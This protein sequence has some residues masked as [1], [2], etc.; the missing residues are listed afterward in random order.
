LGNIGLKLTDTNE[1]IAEVGFM[2]KHDTQGK[3]NANEALNLIK[4][5]F[6]PL[7]LNK[8]VAVCSTGNSGAY[9]LLAK[10]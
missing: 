2:L 1:K 8:I 6:N 7:T 10:R 5:F 9:K 4:E 3:E